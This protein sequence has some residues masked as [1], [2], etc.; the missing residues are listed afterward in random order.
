MHLL[1]RHAYPLAPAIE[2]AYAD[3]QRIIFETDIA[4]MNDPAIQTT[5]LE[6]GLYP[7]GETL[8]Q[9]LDETTRR[10]LEKKLGEL[11]LPPEQFAPFKP[12][13]AAL[14][15]TVLDL[16]RLGYSPNYG[17]DVYFFNKAQADRK[18]TGFLEAPDYQLNLL[19]HMH[20]HDQYLFLRQ[21]LTDLELIPELADN[22]VRYWETGDADNLHSLLFKSFAD[23]P[24]VHDRLLL[25]RNKQWLA[26][27][28]R[29]LGQDR[30][31]LFIV[32]VGHLVGPGSV[33]DLLRKKG[34]TLEQR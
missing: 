25:Q 18:E 1:N 13:F 9:N 21:T 23:Y 15:L 8:D 2:K 11:G 22:M 5:M 26:T 17:V 33:V 3:S 34:Y 20:A 31:V 32:G 30:N 7:P 27:V 12:W 6:L 16:Q 4:A 28:E 19:A 24:A 14:T 10:L 29:A